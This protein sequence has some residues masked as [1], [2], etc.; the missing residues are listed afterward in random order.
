MRTRSCTNRKPLRGRHRVV[1]LGIAL[2]TILLV[3]SGN[4]LGDARFTGTRDLLPSCSFGAGEKIV[5]MIR[6]VEEHAVQLYTFT[7][8][9]ALALS[10]IKQD[11]EQSSAREISSAEKDG[12]K[13]SRQVDSGLNAPRSAAVLRQTQH[14]VL[15]SIASLCEK[16]VRSA[17]GI[18]LPTHTTT[19][20]LVHPAAIRTIKYVEPS[21]SLGT[22]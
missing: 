10:H 17:V 22:V 1:I 3:R 12:D 16:V 18:H 14:Q 4:L 19:L 8:F 5:G 11:L 2:L 13:P 21:S 20:G 7:V 15:H 9:S 6:H